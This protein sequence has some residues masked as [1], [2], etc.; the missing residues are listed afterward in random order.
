MW[1]LVG[2]N[3]TVERA[4]GHRGFKAGDTGRSLVHLQK[5]DASR[6]AHYYGFSIRGSKKN[7]P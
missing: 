3:P 7:P 2:A 6:P 5:R 4:T 1:V